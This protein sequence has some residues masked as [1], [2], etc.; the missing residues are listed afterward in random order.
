MNTI[1]NLVRMSTLSAALALGALT[2]NAL[3]MPSPPPAGMT[4]T[5]PLAANVQTAIDQAVGRKSPDI[6]VVNHNGQIL[7]RG[8]ARTAAEVQTAMNVA[9]RIDGVTD[10]KNN[11]VRLWSSRSYDY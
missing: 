6:E 3:A 9:R 11:G 1:R 8:W 4:H 2:G 7:L 10:V 5:D